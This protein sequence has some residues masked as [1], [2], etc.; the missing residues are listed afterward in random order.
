M[1]AVAKSSGGGGSTRTERIDVEFVSANPTG[2]LTVA[3]G[4][5]AAYGDALARLLEFA[6]HSVTREYYIND[7]GGQVRRLAESVRALARGERCPR[8]ATRATMS[9]S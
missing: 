6:G 9:R 8:T 3:S 4:R 5:H 2:P 7:Y 1:L